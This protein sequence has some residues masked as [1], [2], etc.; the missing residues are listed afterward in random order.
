MVVLLPCVMLLFGFIWRGGGPETVNVIYGYRTVLSMKNMETWR[1]AHIYCG[2]LWRAFGAVLLVVSSLVFAF[3]HGADKD[4]AAWAFVA[5][6]LA[7]VASIIPTILL[8]ER[9]MRRHFN[10]D[11]TRK[12][13]YV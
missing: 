4:V 5:I 8:T 11:G 10:K 2:R 12:T 9:A 7:Q 3:F 13:G 1:F 6:T